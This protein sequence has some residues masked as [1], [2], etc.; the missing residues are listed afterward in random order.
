MSNTP[1]HEI[2]LHALLS[3]KGHTGFAEALS[4]CI[5]AAHAQRPCQIEAFYPC[6]GATFRLACIVEDRKGCSNSIMVVGCA[7]FASKAQRTINVAASSGHKSD[8]D[9]CML[10]HPLLIGPFR[11]DTRWRI[12]G[13]LRLFSRKRVTVQ[14]RHVSL[15]VL[16][17]VWRIEMGGNPEHR[18][19]FITSTE[20]E[21][22]SKFCGTKNMTLGR[23]NF[24]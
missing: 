12:D 20:T 21:G 11:L 7:A 2:T 15:T 14:S 10:M 3:G 17:R 22:L 18:L 1:K 24:Y 13:T 23:P 19:P 9:D 4:G 6:D 8:S 16:K 5:Y